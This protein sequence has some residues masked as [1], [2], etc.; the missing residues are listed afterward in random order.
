L[1]NAYTSPL[2]AD[3]TLANAHGSLM[4]QIKSFNDSIRAT[5]KKKPPSSDSLSP[6]ATLTVS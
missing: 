2:Q 1:V 3:A 6:A 4:A 5:P